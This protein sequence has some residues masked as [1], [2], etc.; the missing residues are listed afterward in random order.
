MKTHKTNRTW[1][2]LGVLVLAMLACKFG[3][4]SPVVTSEPPANNAPPSNTG[5]G[6]DRSHLMLSTV[7]VIME[8]KEGD[9]FIPFGSGSGTIISADGMILTNAHVASPAA[10]GNSADEPDRLTIAITQSEDQPPVLSYVAEVRAVDGSLD[11]AVLQIVSTLNGNAINKADL[12]L[13]FVTLGDS[14]KVHIGDHL[15]IFG[16]PGVGKETITYTEGSVAGFTSEDPPGDRAWIKTAVNIAH[17]NSGGLAADDQGNIIGIPTQ[18]EGDCNQADTNG[19]GQID[20]CI[21]NGN[22]INYL[23]PFNFARPLIEAVQAGKSYTSPYRVPGV[24]SENGSGNEALSD[25][26][27]LTSADEK[28]NPGSDVV[29]SYDSGAVCI[30]PAFKYSGMTKGEAF[31]EVWTRN[32]EQVGEYTYS[33]EWSTEGTFASYFSDEGNPLPSGTYSA[34]FFAGANMRELGTTPEIVVGDA[35][36]TNEPTESSDT[37]TLYGIIY[38]ESTQKPI[39]G[40]YIFVLKAG[41]TYEEW[42]D[43][44]FTEDDV[45][46]S[47]QTGSDGKYKITGIPR[48]VATTYVFSATDY[49]DYW[50]NNVTADDST[51]DLTEANVGL[52]K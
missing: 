17:G 45:A 20:T 26:V 5:G 37:F 49:Y 16:F 40:A 47:L 14:D 48:G 51:A 22:A 10:Q 46:A 30:V 44:N 7:Q 29:E 31:R 36:A 32:G 34:E 24:V 19:D 18:V 6:L 39:S 2:A 13:P 11:L 9:E 43:R 38:D 35:N 8:K 50:E 23:R 15:N 25:F 52:S 4:N 33:W 27:W 12:N 1:I 28:C 41:I 3:A 42:Q 21:P